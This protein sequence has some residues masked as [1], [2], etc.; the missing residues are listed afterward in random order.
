MRENEAGAVR[1]HDATNTDADSSDADKRSDS[2]IMDKKKQFVVE[3]TR[4]FRW[5]DAEAAK[6]DPAL[7]WNPSRSFSFPDAVSVA[8]MKPRTTQ[9]DGI[10]LV[11][12]EQLRVTLANSWDYKQFPFDSH[13]LMVKMNSNS[14]SSVLEP[15]SLTMDPVTLP[16]DLFGF[17]PKTRLDRAIVLGQGLGPQGVWGKTQSIQLSAKLTRSPTHDIFKTLLPVTLC[18]AV[19]YGA[20]F[21]R[22]AQ[23]MPRLISAMMALLMVSSSWAW[24]PRLS[25]LRI[26]DWCGSNTGSEFNRF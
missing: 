8:L 12:E 3:M 4:S 14:L 20:F 10:Y 24:F 15:V 17:S 13:T 2:S 26:P 7:L 9:R 21:L 25:V 6:M 11:M 18:A 19:T 5:P 16:D 22:I 23:L 1:V